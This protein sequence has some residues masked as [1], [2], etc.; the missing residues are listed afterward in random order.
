[1]AQTENN[2]TLAS[3]EE[4]QKAWHNY[5]LRIEQLETNNTAL[6]HE[7]KSLRRLLEN[8]VEHRKSPTPNS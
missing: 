8:V 7:N 6:E 2:A 1:M 5:T 4:I 3:V